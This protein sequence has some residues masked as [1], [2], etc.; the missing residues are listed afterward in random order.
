MPPLHRRMR[1]RD[2][3]EPGRVSTPLELLLDL[4]FVVGISLLVNAFASALDEG[5]NWRVLPAF[6][7]TFF[8]IWWAWNQFTWLASAY[9]TDDVLYRVLAMVQMA[10]VLVLA[11]GVPAAFEH[12]NWLPVTLGYLIMR[13]GLLASLSRAIRDDTETGRVALRYFI[14]ISVVQVFWLLRLLLPHGYGLIE[15][16]F[17]ILAVCELLVPLWRTVPGA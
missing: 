9:D 1:A 3:D 17:V 4:T 15:G 2:V 16:S 14:G 7:M 5:A 11:S 10:G 8:S 6:L 12:D 13:V